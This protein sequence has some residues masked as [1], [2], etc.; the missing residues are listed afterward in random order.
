MLPFDYAELVKRLQEIR[1][2][3]GEITKGNRFKWLLRQVIVSLQRTLGAMRAF[4]ATVILI[5]STAL[6]AAACGE[7]GGPGY[8]G[9]NGK[10]V[11]W[12]AIDRIC[13]SPAEKKCTS[14]SVAA[15]AAD[16]AVTGAMNQARK[17]RAHRA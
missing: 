6:A 9:P 16:A 4:L 7:R 8:R 2:S 13:G 1:G 3:A 17:S 14:E 12:E 15:D 5:F 11:S 10:C